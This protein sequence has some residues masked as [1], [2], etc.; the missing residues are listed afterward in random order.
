MASDLSFPQE[1]QRAEVHP[2]H[3]AVRT[4]EADAK[5]GSVTG[6]AGDLPL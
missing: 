6:A 3:I 1:L 5:T 4:I 2:W